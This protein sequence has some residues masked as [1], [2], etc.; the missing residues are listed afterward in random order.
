MRQVPL[1]DGHFLVMEEVD[2]KHL[3]P[4]REEK[5]GAILFVKCVQ[6]FLYLHITKHSRV[7]GADTASVVEEILL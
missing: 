5:R 6:H 1:S 7:R 3:D 2:W 4:H